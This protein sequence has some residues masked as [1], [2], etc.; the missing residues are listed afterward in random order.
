MASKAALAEGY[1]ALAAAA[2]RLGQHRLAAKLYKKALLVL[3]GSADAETYPCEICYTEAERATP[4]VPIDAL[5]AQGITKR[6]SLADA[7]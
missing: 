2:A 6:E 1:A 5:C 4:S 3:Q 7:R